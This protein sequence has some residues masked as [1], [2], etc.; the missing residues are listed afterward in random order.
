MQQ[1]GIQEGS[2]FYLLSVKIKK[3]TGQEIQIAEAW[4]STRLTTDQ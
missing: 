1:Q 4:F 3:V 2:A